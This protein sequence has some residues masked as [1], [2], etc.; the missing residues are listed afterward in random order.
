M[1]RS[2][3]CD[4]ETPSKNLMPKEGAKRCI[5]V[6][7]RKVKRGSKEVE[8]GVDLARAFRDVS[9]GQHGS[10]PKGKAYERDES[11]WLL[12]PLDFSG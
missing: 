4:Y 2:P 10:L 11:Y 12:S 3:A 6:D 7:W 1:E 8:P 9:A 5:H